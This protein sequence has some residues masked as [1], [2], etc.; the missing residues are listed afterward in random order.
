MIERSIQLRFIS[1]LAY[2]AVALL[3]SAASGGT[4]KLAAS[5]INENTQIPFG[6]AV[7]VGASCATFAFWFGRK[8]QRIEDRLAALEGKKRDRQ[9]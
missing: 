9:G 6:A 5:T 1:R 8:L 3:S 2:L 7:M 4:Y